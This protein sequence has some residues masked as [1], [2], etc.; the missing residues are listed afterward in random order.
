MAR[1]ILFIK[2][3]WDYHD[4]WNALFP[5]GVRLL[6]KAVDDISKGK[7]VYEDQD[8]DVATWEPSWERP[9]LKRNELIML[10]GDAGDVAIREE[11]VGCVY[12][13]RWCPKGL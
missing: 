4:L 7:A 5:I 8:E 2:P 13:C 3:G 9:R 10:G 12:D 1:E 6:V 11:C